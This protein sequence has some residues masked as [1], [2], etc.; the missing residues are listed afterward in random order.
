MTLPTKYMWLES[1]DQLPRTIVEAL[2]L[3]GTKETVGDG[4]NPT[5]L[6]WAQ[7]V[8]LGNQY[9]Q[10]SVPWCGLFADLVV[11]RA[12]KDPVQSPLWALSWKS[13]GTAV[14]QPGLG[15]ILV[16]QRP[17]G[18]HVGFYVAETAT[19]YCVLGGNQG[20][21]VSIIEVAKNRCVGHQRPNYTN[22]PSSVKP[23]YMSSSGHV[24]TNEA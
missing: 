19:T 13:F 15:D 7:E 6:G 9:R 14:T 8:G 3:Y 5:I 12:G 1:I 2:K 11:K 10:D 18:G 16:F 20:D 21:A 23:Y 24:S 22:Q 4:N 17:G